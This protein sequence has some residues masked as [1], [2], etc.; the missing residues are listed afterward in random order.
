M[1]NIGNIT[2]KYDQRTFLNETTDKRRSDP[3]ELRQNENSSEVT[4]EDKVSLSTKS[5]EMQLVKSAVA[6]A[7]DVREQKVAQ[8]KQA[9]ADGQYK[10]DPKK[11]ADKF[12]GSLISEVV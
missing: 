8:I 2:P 12:I 9:I 10:I 11:I 7:P 4:R 5:K 6:D 1:S 3:Q